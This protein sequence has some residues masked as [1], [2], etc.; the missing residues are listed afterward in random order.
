LEVWR[1]A[2]KPPVSTQPE[3]PVGRPTEELEDLD[4]PLRRELD[5]LYSDPNLAQRIQEAL[6]TGYAIGVRPLR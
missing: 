5:E 4:A 6:D 3:Q 2:H 1:N